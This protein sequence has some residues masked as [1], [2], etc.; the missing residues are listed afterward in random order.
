MEQQPTRHWL[1]TSWYQDLK[2]T[3]EV[4]SEGLR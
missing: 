2:V 3:T 4:I 1:Q